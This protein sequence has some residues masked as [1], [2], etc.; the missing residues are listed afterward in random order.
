MRLA[1]GS[2]SHRS[3]EQ[4]D[5]SF[6]SCTKAICWTCTHQETYLAIRLALDSFDDAQVLQAR[7]IT[8]MAGSQPSFLVVLCLILASLM[9]AAR[10]Q[11]AAAPAPA[12]LPRGSPN[13][14]PESAADATAPAP[15]ADMAAPA[16][17]PEAAEAPAPESDTDSP[18]PAPVEISSVAATAARR[19]GPPPS[20][21]N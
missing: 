7:K 11:D 17:A 1:G 13:L 8:Q 12:E 5:R 20:E 16:P 14:A 19:D 6:W 21:P 3:Q 15:A 9:G 10:G 4:R 18:A 2:T